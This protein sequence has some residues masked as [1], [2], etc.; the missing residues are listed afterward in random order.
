M[1]L[2]EL[3]ERCDE[4]V[5]ACTK[6]ALSD[7]KWVHANDRRLSIQ[8][9]AAYATVAAALRTRAAIAALQPNDGGK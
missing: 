6:A 9:A 3:A 7:S 1:T 2:L 4:M 8:E 5:V